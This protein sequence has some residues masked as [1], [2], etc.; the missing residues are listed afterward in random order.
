MIGAGKRCNSYGG[1]GLRSKLLVCLSLVYPRLTTDSQSQQQMRGPRAKQRS[2]ANTAHSSADGIN[3]EPVPEPRPTIKNSRAVSYRMQEFPTAE[4]A[5]IVHSRPGNIRS[6]TF[7][8]PTQLRRDISPV[9]APRLSRIPS[10][11]LTIRTTR[12]NLRTVDP[13]IAES[14]IF[15]DQEDSTLESNSSPDRSYGE[16]SVSPA[17][18]HGSFANLSTASTAKKGPPPPPPSRAKKPPPPPPPAKRSL[19]T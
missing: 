1:N 17:T 13:A 18:S 11:S 14:N 8:G 10:D 19:L 7:E 4:S 6:S 12:S 9:A 3:Q 15:H 5:D 16:R 2:R